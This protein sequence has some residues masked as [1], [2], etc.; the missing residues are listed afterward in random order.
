M[1]AGADLVHPVRGDP[2][3]VHVLPVRARRLKARMWQVQPS[4]RFFQLTP[5]RFVSLILE[6]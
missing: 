4:E 5:A 6:K 1:R 3:Q 2:V